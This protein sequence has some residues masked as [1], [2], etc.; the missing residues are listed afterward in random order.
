ME[1]VQMTIW[2]GV[3]IKFKYFEPRDIYSRKNKVWRIKLFS[4]LLKHRDIIFRLCNAI[5]T[6]RYNILPNITATMSI[7]FCIRQQW[8][9]LTRYNNRGWLLTI[10]SYRR[11]VQNIYLSRRI[12]PYYPKTPCNKRGNVSPFDSINYIVTWSAT[13]LLL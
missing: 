2:S 10:L 5:T 9:I 12:R 13:K 1:H 6:H 7:L 3:T 4:F 8:I 11:F